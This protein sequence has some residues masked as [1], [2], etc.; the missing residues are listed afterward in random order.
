M[1]GLHKAA[2][3]RDPS[4]RSVRRYR[5]EVK[6]GDWAKMVRE[7]V[8]TMKSIRRNCLQRQ[9]GQPLE[10]NEGSRLYLFGKYLLLE[11]QHFQAR[12]CRLVSI[13]P[14]AK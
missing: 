2:L 10:E 8:L 11:L 13:D 4:A 6:R 3:G 9:A 7:M 14:L 5:K 12:L 1:L